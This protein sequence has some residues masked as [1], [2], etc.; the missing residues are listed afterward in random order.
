VLDA[1]RLAVSGEHVGQPLVHLRRL[2]RAVDEDD[3]LRAQGSWTAG[4]S[5]SPGFSCSST[6]P[7][8]TPASGWSGQTPFFGGPWCELIPSMSN[9]RSQSRLRH[10]HRLRRVHVAF[11]GALAE[12]LA[13]GQSEEAGGGSVAEA[14]RPRR[15]S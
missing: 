13:L 2:V 5:T 10:A 11:D 1:N 14:T 6:P 7:F 9:T 12:A 15:T 3:A 8:L 4:Q